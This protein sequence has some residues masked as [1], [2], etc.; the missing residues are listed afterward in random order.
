[1]SDEA[2]P[3]GLNE[4]ELA[5]LST[6][7][8]DTPMT[9]HAEQHS[10]LTNLMKEASDEFVYQDMELTQLDAEVEGIA[11]FLG[12][13]DFTVNYGTGVYTYDTRDEEPQNGHFW[14]ERTG[15]SIRENEY[16]FNK[17]DSQS[18]DLQWS[19]AI[20]GDTLNIV[21]KGNPEDFGTYLITEIIDDEYYHFKVVMTAGNHALNDGQKYDCSVTHKAKQFGDG[22]FEHTHDLTEEAVV[23]NRKDIDDIVDYLDGEDDSIILPTASWMV[24]NDLPPSAQGMWVDN[25]AFNELTTLMVNK[26]ANG[27]KP[28]WDIAREGDELY[29]QLDYAYSQNHGKFNIT[30]FE[31]T[32]ADQNPDPDGDY[33]YIQVEPQS[34]NQGGSQTGQYTSGH[35]THYGLSFP[36]GSVGGD[37]IDLSHEHE[38]YVTREEL[39]AYLEEDEETYRYHHAVMWYEVSGQPGEAWWS[40]STKFILNPKDVE[41]KEPSAATFAPGKTIGL[42][43]ERQNGQEQALIEFKITQSELSNDFG[44][45]EVFGEASQDFPGAAD[46]FMIVNY[47]LPGS[48]A[49]HEHADLDLRIKALEEPPEGIARFKHGNYTYPGHGSITR[50]QPGNFALNVYDAL[51][52]KVIAPKEGDTYTYKINGEEKS[53]VVTFVAATAQQV[54]MQGNIDVISKDGDIIEV[55][56]ETIGVKEHTHDNYADT[57]H[58]HPDSGS[59]HVSDDE[60]ENP[61]EGNL[62]YDTNRLEMFIRYD[63]GWITTTALGARVAEGEAKQREMDSRLTQAVND[64]AALR[65]DLEDRITIALWKFKGYNLDPTTLGGGDFTIHNE[66][67]EG[68]KPLRIWM[69]VYDPSGNYWKTGT[70]LSASYAS[71]FQVS[72]DKPGQNGQYNGLIKAVKLNQNPADHGDYESGIAHLIDLNYV[73]TR[74]SMNEGDYYNISVPGYLPVY[75]QYKR[76]KST[77]F[78]V[79]ADIED[80]SSTAMQVDSDEEI[81]GAS[82][83]EME[84]GN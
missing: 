73:Y 79:D 68:T 20:V 24:G 78:S 6:P 56:A 8:G 13:V 72:I 60:P 75:M 19:K 29:L 12:G 16:V 36:D 9:D 82:D 4:D 41:D 3:G 70:K 76:L 37:Q 10:A 26:Q 61:E 49:D 58:T 40:D 15:F 21:E 55:A 57:D 83:V 11:D 18:N 32:D 7:T 39:A 35:I 80:A 53:F 62:W 33:Y 23:E 27:T 31:T 66:G 52:N 54:V 71:S 25:D 63:G 5:T 44:Y 48:D 51:G 38:Q 43:F 67:L 84:G 14:S 42:R 50:G 59:V 74:R 47:P 64:I 46:N 30:K 1:M 81:Q 65:G 28:A 69:S 77:T 45:W 34:G 17:E 2:I 22:G